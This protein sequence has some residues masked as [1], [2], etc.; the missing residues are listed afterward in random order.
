[1][2]QHTRT[3]TAELV[4]YNAQLRIFSYYYIKFDFSDGGSI[5]VSRGKGSGE[6]VWSRAQ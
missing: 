5:K 3:T 6:G 2:D 1:M 4:T